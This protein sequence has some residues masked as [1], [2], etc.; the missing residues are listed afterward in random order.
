MNSDMCGLNLAKEMCITYAL[1][2]RSLWEIS[3]TMKQKTFWTIM[4]R[5]YIM[6]VEH[7]R[8]IHF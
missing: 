1:P 8:H 6:Y 4:S 3:F 7:N 2:I 5:N